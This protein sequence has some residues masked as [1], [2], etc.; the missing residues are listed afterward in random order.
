MHV[1]CSADGYLRRMREILLKTDSTNGP[2]PRSGHRIVADSRNVYVIGGYVQY[3]NGLNVIGEVWRYNILSNTWRRLSVT[4]FRFP[5]AASHAACIIDHMVVLHGGTGS[6][7]GEKIDN[8][9]TV[10]DLRELRTHM[11]PAVSK[12][13][14]PEDM[15]IPTYGHTLTYVLLDN[16]P[17]LYKVGGA[18]GVTYTMNIYRYSLRF[19][20]WELVY[21]MNHS[22]ESSPEDRYRHDTV[23]YKDKL[24]IIGGANS[25]ATYPLWPMPVFDMRS[26]SWSSLQFSGGEPVQLRY[27]SSAQ[28]NNLV[29]VFGGIAEDLR[30]VKKE[31]YCL[32]LDRQTCS[33]VGTQKSPTFFHDAA[34]V[35]E[36]EVIYSFGGTTQLQT[37]RRTNDLHVFLLNDRPLTLKELAWNSLISLVKLKPIVELRKRLMSISFRPRI[38]KPEVFKKIAECLENEEL[39]QGMFRNH[40]F[41]RAVLRAAAV[42]LLFKHGYLLQLH[43]CRS[44]SSEA[45]FN[46][47]LSQMISRIALKEDT[48]SSFLERVT[49]PDVTHSMCNNT[50]IGHCSPE[51]SLS[52]QGDNLADLEINTAGI[53]ATRFQV[54]LEL[55]NAM[56]E[57]FLVYVFYLL[58]VPSKFIDRLPSGWS[59]LTHVQAIE[60]NLTHCDLS[61]AK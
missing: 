37:E 22:S 42:T 28:V 31:I 52:R 21:D 34:Y 44:I 14:N 19:H 2:L 56:D 15:P 33:I 36:L 30:S 60:K 6:P 18:M 1:C 11:L 24:F 29:F 8:G 41:C 54:H 59:Y 13:G 4:D 5:L 9:L 38:H 58:S 16:Q 61:A 53:F 39:S 3:S 10:V 17:Y 49:V 43:E 45:E 55:Y 27:Q 35:P 12:S 32:D 48:T 57:F 7:F 51:R 26:N 46:F 25:E 20:Q 50:A 23:A 40:S 47:A